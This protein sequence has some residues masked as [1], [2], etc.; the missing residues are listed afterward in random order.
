MSNVLWNPL[1]EYLAE[2]INEQKKKQ[3]ALEKQ[4]QRIMAIMRED[5]QWYEEQLV[6]RANQVINQQNQ[7]EVAWDQ[8]EAEQTRRVKCQRKLTIARR[9]MGRIRSRPYARIP[10][11]FLTSIETSEEESG[12]EEEPEP[13]VTV[14]VEVIDL[15]EE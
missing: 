13:E 10:E 1:T 14:V 12:E 5:I 2:T 11:S 6:M 8:I 4:H 7:L 9:L 15:T 3:E